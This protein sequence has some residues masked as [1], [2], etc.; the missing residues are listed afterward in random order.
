ML[1]PTSVPPPGGGQ[2]AYAQGAY[3]YTDGEGRRVIDPFFTGAAAFSEGKASVLDQRGNA[4]FLDLKGSLAIPHR[5]T[6]LGRFVH[7]LCATRG[8]YINHQGEWAIPPRF[9]VDSNFSEG[10]AFAS[11]DGEHFGFIGLD[12]NSVVEP[13]FDQCRRFSEGLAAVLKG[14]RWGYIDHAGDFAIPAVFEGKIV[15]TF[16]EG[17]AGACVDGKY[18]LIDTHGVFV[19]K[20][21]YD[22]IGVLAENRV[23]VQAGGKWGLLD[24]FGNQIVECLFDEIRSFDG[25]IAPARI[26]NKAGFI[27]RDGRW[28]FE[29][30]FK[31]S[32]GFVGEL[33]VV[34]TDKVWSCINR[35]KA[36]T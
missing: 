19:V 5:S 23:R 11:F 22:L 17:R 15:T 4:G 26:G 36:I 2:G 27:E 34:V 8:G 30:R 28:A 29:P 6:G 33:A 24:R 21:E 31:R 13:D 3:G 35:L 10:P 20:P 9:L 12:G 18:G 32:F 1:Y 7:G 14:G 25:G 16:R